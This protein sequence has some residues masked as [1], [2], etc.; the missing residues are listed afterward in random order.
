MQI[1]LHL[2]WGAES[3]LLA[4]SQMMVLLLILSA[5]R[6]DPLASQ[7]V[8]LVDQYQVDIYA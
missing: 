8:H 5:Q 6:T 2:G 4:S 1:R 3:E 7:L